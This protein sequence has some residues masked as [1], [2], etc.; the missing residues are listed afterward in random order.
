V[1]IFFRLRSYINFISYRSQDKTQSEVECVA[2]CFS[3]LIGFEWKFV[4]ELSANDEGIWVPI[5]LFPFCRGYKDCHCSGERTPTHTGTLPSF[6][7]E[8]IRRCSIKD[9]A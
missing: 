1:N 5:H 7:R 2:M 3:K 8:N 4:V 9:I 6:L